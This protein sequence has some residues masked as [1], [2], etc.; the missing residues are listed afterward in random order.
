M[1]K[2]FIYFFNIR[3]CQ[4]SVAEGKEK[5][6]EKKSSQAPFYSSQSS[7][8]WFTTTQALS[9]TLLMLMWLEKTFYF[10]FMFVC[11]S[12]SMTNVWKMC[13]TMRNRRSY[14]CAWSDRLSS[15]DA[16]VNYLC[17]MLCISTQAAFPH[18]HICKKKGSL[19]SRFSRRAVVLMFTPAIVNMA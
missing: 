7:R 1:R 6:E 17:F 9:H 18:F 4:V 10:S 11:C 15:F 12:H 14:S 8:G 5:E 16:T 19:F 3:N 2:S 13:I